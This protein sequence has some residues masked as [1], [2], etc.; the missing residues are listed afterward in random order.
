M[1]PA[2]YLPDANDPTP[3]VVGSIADARQLAAARRQIQG[4]GQ[5]VAPFRRPDGTIVAGAWLVDEL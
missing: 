5:T 1:K 2:A 3:K 4:T